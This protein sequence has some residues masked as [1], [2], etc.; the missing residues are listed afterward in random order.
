MQADL[1]HPGQSFQVRVP[2]PGA[3]PP[4]KGAPPP[5]EHYRFTRPAEGDYMLQHINF[6]PMLQTLQG[7]SMLALFASLL[8]ERRVVFV[9][10]R[11][12][13]LSQVVLSFQ[14]RC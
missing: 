1:P 2:V 5:V 7:T 13:S 9:S 10:A 3:P 12:S 11:L 4:V 6:V 14:C 8:L